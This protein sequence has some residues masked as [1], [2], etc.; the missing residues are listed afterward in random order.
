MSIDKQYLPINLWV[1]LI[2]SMEF[3]SSIIDYNKNLRDGSLIAQGLGIVA[4]C[5][6]NPGLIPVLT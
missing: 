5:V 2:Q 1:Y 4:F 3:D 6:A